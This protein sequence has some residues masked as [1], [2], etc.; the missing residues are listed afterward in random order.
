MN[1]SVDPPPPT[2]DEENMGSSTGYQG[3]NAK[4]GE[5]GLHYNKAED[6]TQQ[7]G[8]HHPYDASLVSR[9]MPSGTSTFHMPCASSFY[10]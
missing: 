5:N 4:L 8:Y 9:R 3:K 6:K 7:T 10:G 1:L 2:T